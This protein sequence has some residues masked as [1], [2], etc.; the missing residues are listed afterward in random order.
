MSLWLGGAQVALAF[1][2]YIID[3]DAKAASE[4][5]EPRIRLRGPLVRTVES[6]QAEDDISQ[7]ARW[8]LHLPEQRQQPHADAVRGLLRRVQCICQPKVA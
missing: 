4:V 3:E 1:G 8:G 7:A 2:R 5:L 6:V